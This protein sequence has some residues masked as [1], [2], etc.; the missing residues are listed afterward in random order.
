MTAMFLSVEPEMLG[1]VSVGTLEVIRLLQ[2]HARLDLAEAKGLVDRCVFDGQTVRVPIPSTEA[3]T[4]LI[5]A[6][7]ELPHS[8]WK[9]GSEAGSGRGRG[10][11]TLYLGQ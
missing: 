11:G 4:S 3:A 10:Y 8:P 1:P 5:A 2:V 9:R 6:I 7:A